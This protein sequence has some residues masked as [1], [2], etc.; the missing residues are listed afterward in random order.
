MIREDITDQISGSSAHHK[1][2]YV[3]WIFHSETLERRK[4]SSD[5]R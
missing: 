1:D 3:L 4:S 2:V 5:E